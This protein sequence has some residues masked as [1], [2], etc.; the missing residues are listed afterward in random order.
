MHEP[1]SS[2]PNLWPTLFVD[3]ETQ[4]L[5]RVRPSLVKAGSVWADFGRSLA[6]RLRRWLWHL[7]RLR[8]WLRLR[9]CLRLRRWLWRWLRRWSRWPLR[10]RLGKP[11]GPNLARIRQIDPNSVHVGSK[12]DKCGQRRTIS[13]QIQ[14]EVGPNMSGLGQRWPQYAD[15]G[16][17]GASVPS[18]AAEMLGEIHAGNDVR[19]LLQQFRSS[20]A[21]ACAVGDTWRVCVRA[22]RQAPNTHLFVLFCARFKAKIPNTSRPPPAFTVRGYNVPFPPSSYSC[23]S[24]SS[25]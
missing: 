13:G 4:I 24:S 1:P 22:A 20:R 9:R 6:K 17:G 11:V 7:R 14:P 23:S 16:K 3:V 2:R 18:G 21:A 25:S 19:A 5:G 8:R 10:T 15:I 12:S